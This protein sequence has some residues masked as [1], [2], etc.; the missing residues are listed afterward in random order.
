MCCMK[1]IGMDVGRKNN[2]SGI[3]WLR[4]DTERSIGLRSFFPTDATIMAIITSMTDLALDLL[5]GPASQSIPTMT[6][7]GVC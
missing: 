7:G 1:A 3:F 5:L 6:A 4:T 2:F